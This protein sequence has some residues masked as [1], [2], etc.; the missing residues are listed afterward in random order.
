[1]LLESVEYTRPATVEEAL[2]A[3]ASND[4]AAPLAGGQ[5]LI[6]VLKNRVASVALLVDISRLDELRAVDVRSDGS[7]EVGGR[8]RV[9]RE[10]IVERV[11]LA[12]VKDRERSQRQEPHLAWRGQQFASRTTMPISTPW[13]SV[14]GNAMRSSA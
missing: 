12:L 2:G 11:E 14:T 9:A 8:W 7:L 10:R 5:S 6:N 13:E 3:L 4:G 1:M